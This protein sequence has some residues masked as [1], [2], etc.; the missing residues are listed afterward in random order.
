VIE[1][2]ELYEKL[3]GE[4]LQLPPRK[5]QNGTM[6]LPYVFVGDEAFTLREDFLKSFS[7]KDRNPERKVFNYRLSRAR[8]IVENILR[9]VASRFRIFHTQINLKLDRIETI[10]MTCCVLHNYLRRRCTSFGQEESN[11]EEFEGDE[12][13]SFPLQ[14]GFSRHWGQQGR[15]VRDM[16]CSTSITKG[17]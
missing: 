9:I 10:V 8:R 1:N 13:V 17:K 2:T 14:K 15:I 4:H 3:V 16:Y 11:T 12:N 6:D 5:P 7:Q